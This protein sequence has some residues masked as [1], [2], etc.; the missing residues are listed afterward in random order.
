MLSLK[1]L[2]ALG[3][4]PKGVLSYTIRCGPDGIPKVELTR[5]VTEIDEAVIREGVEE[6]EL[7]LVGFHRGDTMMH[8]AR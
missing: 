6:Y 5:L 2:A 8:L 7:R 3:I 1:I 4:D